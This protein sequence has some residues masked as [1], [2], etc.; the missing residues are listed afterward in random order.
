MYTADHAEVYDLLYRGRGKDYAAEAALV[1]DLAERKG[2]RPSSLLD[3][4]CGTGAHLEH[5]AGL[6]E[7]VEGLE[8][9]AEMIGP[10]RRRVPSARLHTADMRDFSLGTTFSLVTCMFSSIGYMRDTL[11]LGRALSCMA[12]HL[13]PGG[14]LV[15]EPWWFPET[16]IEGY[17]SAHVVREGDRTVSRVSHSVLDGRETVMEVHFVVADSGIGVRHFTDVHRITL[18]TKEEYEA[19]FRSAGLEVG[20]LE[21]GPSG[22]GLL[23]GTLPA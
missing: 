14:T 7:R 18:F 6:V 8:L 21:G 15:V 12:R 9:S 3:V 5:F 22:R 4:A 10:A 11:E 20:F 23:V 19:A 2:H 16:F 17:V 13:E 1:V